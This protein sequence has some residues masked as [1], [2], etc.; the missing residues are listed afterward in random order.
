METKGIQ[1]STSWLQTRR[2][3]D[4]TAGTC[5]AG[6]RTGEFVLIAD[7]SVDKS[8]GNPSRLPLKFGGDQRSTGRMEFANFAMLAMPGHRSGPGA[9]ANRPG[10]VANFRAGASRR[11]SPHGVIFE[12][13]F[14]PPS[15]P[16][17]TSIRAP[18]RFDNL[19]KRG[20]ASCMS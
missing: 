19:T 18:A 16:R 4:C 9:Y 11:N 5:G 7:R 14:L 10:E 15:G 3:P 20:K 17:L 1:P 8:G 13:I 12:S 6:D 2:F